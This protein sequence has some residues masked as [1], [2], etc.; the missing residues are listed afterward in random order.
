MSAD[1]RLNEVPVTEIPWDIGHDDEPITP[2]PRRYGVY[3]TLIVSVVDSREM[4]TVQEF[5]V[6]G[7]VDDDGRSDPAPVD[8]LIGL[9]VKLAVHE[10]Q[11]FAA[12]VATNLRDRS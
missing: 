12:A 10:S 5:T 8:N 9:A 11:T 7:E 4:R 6:R 1:N 3:T 2:R